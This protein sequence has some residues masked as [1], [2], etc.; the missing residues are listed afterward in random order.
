[1]G[2]GHADGVAGERRGVAKAVAPAE[3]VAGGVEALDGRPVGL[4]DVLGAVGD[5]AGHGDHHGV[6]AV[7]QVA[8][9]RVERRRVDRHHVGLV[10]AVVGVAVL[11]VAQLVVVGDAVEEVLLGVA[12]VADHVGELVEGLGGVDGAAHHLALGEVGADDEAALG[13]ADLDLVHRLLEDVHVVVH[14]EVRRAVVERGGAHGLLPVGVGDPGALAGGLAQADGGQLGD[15]ALVA[16]ALAL[17]VAHVERAGAPR[18]ARAAA[19][20]HPA[21]GRGLDHAARPDAHLVAGAGARAGRGP[22]VGGRAGALGPLHALV[23]QRPAHLG[24]ADVVAGGEDD[25]LGGVELHVVAVGVGG[26]QAGHVA[27]LVL[28]EL[29]AGVLVVPGRAVLLRVLHDVLVDELDVVALIAVELGVAR[30][31]LVAAALDGVGHAGARP[32]GLGVAQRVLE[33]VGHVELALVRHSLAVDHD[34]GAA[35]EH[36]GVVGL[37]LLLVGVVDLLVA[38][39]HGA[40]VLDERLDDVGVHAAAGA[41][42]ELAGDLAGVERAE[43]AVDEELRVDVADVLAVPAALVGAGTLEVDERVPGLLLDGGDGA[44]LVDGAQGGHQAG[45]AAA[46]DD[47]VDVI[48]GGDLVGGDLGL[49]AQPVAGAAVAP[50]AA[51]VGDLSGGVGDRRG[52]TGAAGAAGAGGREGGGGE[53]RRGGQARARGGGG[54]Q[55]GATGHSLAHENI[56]SFGRLFAKGRCAG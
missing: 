32:C 2:H 9:A 50:H 18:A 22:V 37:A 29:D 42:A 45:V 10:L 33:H 39:E 38:V 48:G 1:M 4:H 17:G 11:G 55:K 27:R 56:L 8:G 43:A 20:A 44:A 7:G 53:G 52:A 13:V 21:A 36:G 54:G 19:E 23:Q 24:V 35:E 51:V 31:G 49:G 6:G 28:D 25:T 34:L 16:E 5:Q 26:D 15:C 30:P 40:G 47:D 14:A 46:E 41:L 12:L 3:A